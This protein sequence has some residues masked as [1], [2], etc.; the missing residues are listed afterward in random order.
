M[1]MDLISVVVTIYN[2][3][4]YLTKCISSICQ[5]T[6]S[7]LEIILVNDGSNDGSAEICDCFAK[8]DSR[9][10]VMHKKNEGV[11]RARVDGCLRAKGKYISIV[12]SDDWLEDDMLEKL[13][14]AIV[15]NEVDVAMCGRIEEFE[16]EKKAVLQGVSAGVYK[17]EKLR[18]NVYPRMIT[19]DSFFEWGI[20]PSYW[21][22]LFKRK[23]LMPYVLSVDEAICIGNDA[24]G[25]FPC[26]ADSDSIC[27]IGECLYHYRQNENSIVHRRM[28]K[29]KLSNSFRVLYQS[30]DA[31]LKKNQYYDFSEQWKK[32][33]LFLIVPRAQL[34][35]KGMIELDY[36]FP[37]PNVKRGSS[38]AIYGMGLYG[39]RLYD[40]LKETGFCQVVATFDRNFCNICDYEVS[41]PKNVG[42]YDFDYIVITLSYANSRK[43]VYKYLANI[44]PE[45]KIQQIDEEEVFSNKT[46]KAIGL[47]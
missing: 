46:L 2:S 1:C 45:Y 43:T 33:V 14:A 47:I 26:L 18:N 9:I 42:A 19:N 31:K 6:Y 29:N 39:R 25:V 28:D 22:K 11:V 4:P 37:F 30:V 24:A 16:N 21:D 44:V 38:I 20:F 35:Y 5:Q 8:L 40:F 7:K 10:F 17:G 12:D 23:Q 36:L 13:Y 34:L 3:A 41:D 15:T 32:Y 27:V